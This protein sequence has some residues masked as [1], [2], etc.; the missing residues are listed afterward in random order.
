MTRHYST[1]NNWDV[2]WT[3]IYW[4]S[5]LCFCP[6]GRERM[7]GLWHITAIL[8]NHKATCTVACA[9][10]GDAPRS[11]CSSYSSNAQY[12]GW[13]VHSL[14]KSSGNTGGFMSLLTTCRCCTYRSLWHKRQ[15][16]ILNNMLVC[17]VNNTCLYSIYDD[18]LIS[19][20]T[21]SNQLFI[22]SI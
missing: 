2:I 8:A 17:S 20:R 13:E 5:I 19:Q 16:D 10:W 9:V 14:W 22:Y 4:L 3:L 1:G 7:C 21:N 18:T 12:E 11:G 6:L 15:V